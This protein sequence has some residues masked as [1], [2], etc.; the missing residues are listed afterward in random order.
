MLR[1]LNHLL[2]VPPEFFF[3]VGLVFHLFIDGGDCLQNS[4]ELIR[5]EL[6]RVED[7]AFLLIEIRNEVRV[8]LSLLNLGCILEGV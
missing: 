1:V 2:D 8:V 5:F 4:F 6:V 3:L 7:L